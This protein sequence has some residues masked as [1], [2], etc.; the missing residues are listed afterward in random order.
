MIADTLMQASVARIADKGPQPQ[1]AVILGSGLGHFTRTLENR[2][3]IPYAEIPLFPPK[4][5]EGHQGKLVLGRCD[6]IE[7]A[8]FC[9]RFH[10]YQGL[11]AFTAT[12]PVRLAA[13][14]GC[15]SILLTS[16]V[17]GIGTAFVPGD[18]L[19]VTDHLNFSSHNPL[20]GMAPPAFV[21]LSD[22]YRMDFLSALEQCAAGFRSSI[23]PGVLAY[24]PGP[25]YETPAEIT[26]LGRLG[27]DAV[28]MS[29]V[30]EAIMARALDLQ[31]ASLALVTNFA[32]GGGEALSHQEVLSCAEVSA[33][34][35]AQLVQRILGFLSLP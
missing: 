34:P 15:R 35:F 17:G 2:V 3:E 20:S 19:L 32:A 21:D 12:A 7:L 24:M 10:V 9:G 18:F 14:L 30:L 13:A 11:D 6:E 8:V 5:V 26:A 4:Q 16:A 25:S 28:G 27:A 1:V 31:V 23:R 33:A 22:C 29:S